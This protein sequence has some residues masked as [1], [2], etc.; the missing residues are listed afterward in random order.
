MNPASLLG[1]NGDLALIA[2]NGG[3]LHEIGR[4]AVAGHVS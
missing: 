3:H 1:A 2:A 4:V